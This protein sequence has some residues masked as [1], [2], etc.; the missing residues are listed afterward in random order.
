MA[1]DFSNLV[2]ANNGGAYVPESVAQRFNMSYVPVAIYQQVDFAPGSTTQFVKLAGPTYQQ[3]ANNTIP[4]SML[5]PV[6]Q[7]ILKEGM[8]PAVDY[9]MDGGQIRN[10]VLH[11]S[12][13]AN[14]KPITV[15]IDQKLTNNNNL[16]GRFTRVPNYGE[17]SRGYFSG[18]KV[19]EFP[20]DY[21]AGTQ[22]MI[23]DTWF[24]GSIVNDLKVNYLR[25]NFS[26][27]NAPEWQTKNWSTE[28]GLPALTEGGLPQ[29]NFT[30]GGVFMI[31]QNTISAIGR[32]VEQSDG[33]TDMLTWQH[34]NMLWKF[35]G[36]IRFQSQNL[37]NYG[38]ASGGGYRFTS[39]YTNSANTGAS[40]GWDFATF[41]L[42]IP[43]QSV[44]LR[45]SIANYHYNWH[46]Y[47]F[48][49]QNDWRVTPSLTL[50]LGVRYD[51]AK[52][53]TEQNDMQAVL[54]PDP[55]RR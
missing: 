52:P 34:G 53:R 3:F 37:V 19:N 9:F 48:F 32:R 25:G 16:Y 35:G 5:D 28:L 1:G 27:T 42:G 14:Q 36:D 10:Y 50:N 49:V 51:L 31:G 33:L 30:G 41:L 22:A 26:S 7:R 12:V 15:K 40:G 4:S 29:F 6:A 46:S 24:R 44:D 23:G 17:R 2:N 47:S 54:R 55:A 45:N 39:A 21:S 43:N 20:T 8:P 11:R 13:I 18:S 38:T